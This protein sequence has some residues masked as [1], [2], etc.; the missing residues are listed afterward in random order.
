MKGAIDPQTGGKCYKRINWIDIGKIVRIE[1]NI[2]GCLAAYLHIAHS[3]FYNDG[4]AF[5]LMF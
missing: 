5:F 2:W 3:G 4:C 1:A